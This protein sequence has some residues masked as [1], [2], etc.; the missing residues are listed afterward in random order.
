MII[1]RPVESL[2]SPISIV[3]LHARHAGYW[4]ELNSRIG[5]NSPKGAGT[6]GHLELVTTTRWSRASELI[7]PEWGADSR[8]HPARLRRAGLS[9]NV[10]NCKNLSQSGAWLRRWNIELGTGCAACQP[11]VSER[12]SSCLTA[13][14]GKKEYVR[15][16]SQEHIFSKKTG[17]H[18]KVKPGNCSPFRTPD[19]TRCLHFQNWISKKKGSIRHQSYY[20]W[21]NPRYM[22]LY[23][24]LWY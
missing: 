24:R 21:L 6:T 4:I 9:S 14:S 2:T 5:N 22:T 23:F 12:L 13:C 18:T 16:F 19:F 17:T 1:N 7:E 10:T 11:D 15:W 8:R 20:K 3:E